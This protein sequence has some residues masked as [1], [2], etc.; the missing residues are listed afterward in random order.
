MSTEHHRLKFLE[1]MLLDHAEPEAREGLERPR[2]AAPKSGRRLRG[3]S[4][5]LQPADPEETADD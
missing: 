3:S 5:M 1:W 2:R 4:R